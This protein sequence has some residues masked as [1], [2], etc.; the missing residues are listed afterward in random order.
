MTSTSHEKRLKKFNTIKEENNEEYLNLQKSKLNPNAIEFKPHKLVDDILNNCMSEN[1]KQNSVENV[2]QNS[3]KASKS[4]SARVNNENVQNSINYMNSIY[5]DASLEHDSKMPITKHK[6]V[7]KNYLYFNVTNMNGRILKTSM[8]THNGD[9]TQDID[10]IKMQATVFNE[11]N[12]GR[13]SLNKNNSCFSI[14]KIRK[15]EAFLGISVCNHNDFK[16]FFK[17]A[18]TLLNI[19]NLNINIIPSYIMFSIVLSVLILYDIN[20]Y[21]TLLSN[22]EDVTNDEVSFKRSNSHFNIK[23]NEDRNENSNPQNI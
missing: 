3:K 10:F 4:P 14:N 21:S 18:S 16:D 11:N 13:V 12:S 19:L 8:K 20:D 17:S 6:S 15:S 9:K 22:K 5:D 7:G 1:I 2:K 23:H